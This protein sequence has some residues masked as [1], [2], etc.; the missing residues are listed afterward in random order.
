M[1]L[2][3]CQT[4]RRSGSTPPP[5]RNN[6]EINTPLPHKV[7]PFSAPGGR[8]IMGD[9]AGNGYA[10]CNSLRREQE[11]RDPLSIQKP[12]P[13]PT[14]QLMSLSMRGDEATIA[15]FCHLAA[16]HIKSHSFTLPLPKPLG[17]QK[18]S[19]KGALLLAFRRISTTTLAEFN[20]FYNNG[21]QNSI[22]RDSTNA[23]S[24]T[25]F[26]FL[27]LRPSHSVPLHTI[28]F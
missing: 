20:Y 5:V 4:C 7:L 19:T 24:T 15:I 26:A 17:C 8:A 28:L 1:K 2:W 11:I 27:Y 14:H 12:L 23:R 3:H 16:P 18:Q 9:L 22:G 6:I 21:V 10:A 25:A 13:P